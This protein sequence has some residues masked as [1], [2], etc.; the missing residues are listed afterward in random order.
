LAEKEKALAAA[1]AALSEA[2]SQVRQLAAQVVT[3]K[4]QLEREQQHLGA[5]VQ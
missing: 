2:E 5:Q 3:G 4:A 1:A